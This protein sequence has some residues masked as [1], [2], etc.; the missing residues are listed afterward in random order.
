MS[1]TGIILREESSLSDPPEMQL[2]AHMEQARVLLAEAKTLDAARNVE[3]FMKATLE[4]ARRQEEIGLAL[5]NDA[6]HLW[7]E[8]K[9]TQGEML[10]LLDKNMGGRPKT[11]RFNRTVLDD[12]PTLRDLG[13]RHSQAEC[14]QLIAYLSREERCRLALAATGQGEKL[15]Q[16]ALLDAAR[17]AQA[18]EP[19][20]VPEEERT[21]Y[22]SDIPEEFRNTVVTG[23]ARKL[24]PM[25]SDG[26]VALCFCDPVYDRVE[27]YE[28]LAR[29]CER[30]L[31][32][33]GSL[34]VQSGNS[35]R[36]DC[37][38]AMRKSGLQFVDLLAEVYPYGIGRLFK[39]KTF[40]GW[41]PYLWF[42]KGPRTSGWV[43]NRL[44]VGGKPYSD[45]SKGI[46]P[47]GDSDQFALGLIGRLCGAGD[48]VFDPFTGSG[49]VPA[50]A[51][52]L[53]L[54]FVAF[55]IDPTTAEQARQRVAGTRRI[56]TSQK[57]IEFEEC[58]LA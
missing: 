57:Q 33:G 35:R 4:W 31:A 15:T 52:K 40:V 14:L 10:S 38:V 58:P 19:E 22:P 53:G 27:D 23:D 47:W 39:A 29:E 18:P 11:V 54:P 28:W 13:Y 51:A 16:K 46:H 5:R 9:A 7:L 25:L 44:A 45:D 3:G 48:L 24:T 41:K 17:K 56:V 21:E 26:S 30:V 42:S 6:V 50:V 32:P 2:L 43:V 12:K 1:D 36:F 49:V 20:P 55:E 8:A 37:E 34:I